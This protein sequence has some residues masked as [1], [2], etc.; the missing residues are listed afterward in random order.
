[1]RQ[2]LLISATANS[3]L[4]LN[5]SL[6]IQALAPFTVGISESSAHRTVLF[7]FVVLSMCVFMHVCVLFCKHANA[8]CPF[9][10]FCP[11]LGVLF[12]G[13]KAF[14]CRTLMQSR[15][16]LWMLLL[17]LLL[18]PLLLL[19]LPLLLLLLLYSLSNKIEKYRTK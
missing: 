9:F 3:S 4:P 7:L 19:P 1:M 8:E 12:C 13:R 18:P 17:L 6:N 14:K 11:L 15:P 10:G 2:L 5:T 16:D